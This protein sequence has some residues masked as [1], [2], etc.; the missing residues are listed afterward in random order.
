MHDLDKRRIIERYNARFAEHGVSMAT[1]ASGTEARR[2]MRYEVLL[3]L[4]I[5]DGDSVLDLGCGFGDFAG[6]LQARGIR[7]HYTGYDIN[8]VLVKAAQARHPNREFEVRD[9]FAE[10]FPT[11]DYIVSSSAFNLP[12]RY[13]DN[14]A[15]VSRL[16]RVCHAHAHRGVAIDFLSSYVDFR[17]AEGFHYEP[18]RVLQ[19]AKAITKRVTLR[20][21]YPLFEFCVY[22][23]ADFT[24]WAVPAGA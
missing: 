4:G 6:F 11:F 20:H 13:E 17:S 21:D 7:A 19:L 22:L 8:P 5:R 10:P 24:G 23:F 18:E 9:V 12:L 14:Y 16:F 3:E 2:T 15:F 1:M